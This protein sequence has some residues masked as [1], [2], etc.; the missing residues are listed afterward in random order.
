M[1]VTRTL[2]EALVAEMLRMS[3]FTTGTGAATKAASDNR[4]ELRRPLMVVFGD[5]RAAADS[6][7]ASDSIEAG[8][9]AATWLLEDGGEETS[10]AC[11]QHYKVG[12]LCTTMTMN[13]NQPGQGRT[14]CSAT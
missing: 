7:E 2:A 13:Q 12:E 14:A 8:D 5:T 4:A 9:S 1:A 11:K 6:I 10:C 3:V